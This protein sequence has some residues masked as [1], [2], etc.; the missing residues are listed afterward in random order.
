MTERSTESPQEGFQL[1]IRW[2]GTEDNPLLVVNQFLG[3][4]GPTQE[5][6]LSFGA[7]VPPP[8]VGGTIEEQTE[9]LKEHTY[10]PAKVVARLGV[11]R[12][13]LEQLIEVL[14]QTLANYDRAWEL[15]EPRA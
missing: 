5:I 13:A 15:E 9:Q 6:I 1:P 14:Q 10:V 8:I 4:V 12:I 11:S 3:Q 2:V 7:A